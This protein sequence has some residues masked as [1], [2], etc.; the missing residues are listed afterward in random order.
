MIAVS[1]VP[2]RMLIDHPAAILLVAVGASVALSRYAASGNWLP[3]GMGASIALVVPLVLTRTKWVIVA[4]FLITGTLLSSRFG[5]FEIG[6]I[7]SDL[8]EVLLLALL[9][10]WLLQKAL[11]READVIPFAYATVGLVAAALAGAAIAL[12][13]GSQFGD[14]L[15]PLKTFLFWLLVLP[16]ASVLRSQ[17]DLDW[18]ERVVIGIAVAASALT[19]ALA[20]LGIGVPSGD[21][22]GITSLGVYSEATR[23]RP[24]SLQLAFLAAFLLS[25]RVAMHRWSIRRGA[26]MA[27]L[28]LAQAISFNRSTW[29]AL[30]VG[31]GLYAAFRPGNREPLRGLS[32]GIVS[33][34]VLLGSLFLAGSGALGGSAEAVALR[35]RSVVTP[36]VFEER[37]Q[38]LRNQ[39]N[40]VA[41]S[42]LRRSPLTGVGLNRPFGNRSAVYSHRAGAVVYS[43]TL[44][45][46]NTYLKLWLET[47]I[48]GIIALIGLALATRKMARRQ[49]RAAIPTLGSRSLAAALCLLGFALQAVYQTK[50]YHRPTIIAA[51]AALAILA[52][53]G[54]VAKQPAFVDRAT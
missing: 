48:F 19:L 5:S 28:L 49:T 32:V 38:E 33:L 22:A 21:V 20:V 26:G 1:K 43:D 37:S 17:K 27:V 35:A 8:P 36:S 6:G 25:H 16:L 52:G 44:L 2:T 9:G 11:T 34:A 50:L 29:V 24:A 13:R 14:V 39:E 31:L 10:G 45:I 30:V 47:G 41:L 12:G 40:A 18:L 54:F 51:T 4:L 23:Y 42:A 46:H 7:R 3:A 15:G 53:T